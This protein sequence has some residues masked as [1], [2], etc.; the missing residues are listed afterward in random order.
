MTIAKAKDL[1]VLLATLKGDASDELLQAIE[2]PDQAEEVKV[3]EVPELK[4]IRE[5]DAEI[6]ESK[7]II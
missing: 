5:A 4:P 1:D 3:E 7:S 2:N 6:E